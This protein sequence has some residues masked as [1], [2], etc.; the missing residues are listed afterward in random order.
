MD[1]K[2]LQ[3]LNHTVFTDNFGYTPLTERLSDIAN[4]NIELQRAY[5]VLNL[6]EEAGDM[7]ASLI[8]L[9]TENGWDIEENLLSTHSKINS[10]HL[11]Y[12][13]LGRK[14]KVCILGGNFSPIHNGHIQTAQFILN[15][16]RQFDEIWLLP[17]YGHMQKNQEVSAED[18]LEMC[19]LAAQVDA[20]IKVFDYE[21]KNK[22]AGETYYF[23]KRLMTEEK[24][25]DIYNFSLAIGIDN[26]NKFDTWVNYE[27][28]EKLAKFVV[29]PRKGIE[30]DINVDWYLKSPHIYLHGE[31]DIIDMSS[32]YIRNVVKN[33]YSSRNDDD[34]QE[35]YD[36]M[37]EKVVD[38]IIKKELYK[39]DEHK[40]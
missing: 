9:H 32:T 33:Y 13:S 21:I 28:L 19:K 36:N 18:R 29:I 2:K 34:L 26:A 27:E 38:Y 8:E 7:L 11:Q 37:N 30:R 10:R 35:L 20:R 39:D 15:T 6:K 40:K 4:E 5:S 12:K 31:N 23:I 3:K 14:T 17:A 1:I 24:L 16:T 22:L 25:N